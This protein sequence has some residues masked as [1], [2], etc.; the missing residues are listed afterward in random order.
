MLLCRFFIPN[1]L[2]K[3]KLRIWCVIWFYLNW[4]TLLEAIFN[5]YV[6]NMANTYKASFQ[7][8]WY[9]IFKKKKK[10]SYYLQEKKQNFILDIYFL[11]LVHS[12]ICNREFVL[13]IH[14]GSFFLFWNCL[15]LYLRVVAYEIFE[16]LSRITLIR[17]F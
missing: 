8:F 11:A 6:T 1:F 14:G 16:I 4:I 10:L 7:F 12:Y 15:Y 2:D 17:E 13:S 5:F 3:P 9:I